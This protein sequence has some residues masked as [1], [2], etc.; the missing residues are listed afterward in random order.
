VQHPTRQ[1]SSYLSPQETQMSLTINYYMPI[2]EFVRFAI[3]CSVSIICT[4]KKSH[5]KQNVVH[6][7]KV[8][9][10]AFLTPKSKPLVVLTEHATNIWKDFTIIG[11]LYF[12]LFFFQVQRSA[13]ITVSISNKQCQLQCDHDKYTKQ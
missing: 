9:A 2:S 11:L 7:C 3:N 8:C 4:E 5:C 6:F 1:I 12:W 10:S 13:M